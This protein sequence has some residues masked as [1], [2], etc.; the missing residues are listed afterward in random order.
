VSLHENA[1]TWICLRLNTC[2]AVRSCRQRN[3]PCRFVQD[4]RH[5]V[6]S[7]GRSASRCRDTSLPWV[8]TEVARSSCCGIPPA[9]GRS[10]ARARGA[11]RGFLLSRG[12]HRR[13]SHAY[14]EENRAPQCRRTGEQA[15]S[16]ACHINLDRNPAGK[17]SAGKSPDT[18]HEICTTP[19]RNHPSARRS[20]EL[21]RWNCYPA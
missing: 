13:G 8:F 1:T 10:G 6:K 12:R 15:K 20:V 7:D 11:S 19:R 5:L 18:F 14:V 9:H 4:S 2:S 16:G 17:R 21:H 3:Q